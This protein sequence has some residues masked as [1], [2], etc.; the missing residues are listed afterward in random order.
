MYIPNCAYNLLR[1]NHVTHVGHGI[2]K[3]RNRYFLHTSVCQVVEEH[4]RCRRASSQTP[5]NE[6]RFFQGEVTNSQSIRSVSKIGVCDSGDFDYSALLYIIASTNQSTSITF[7]LYLSS[8]TNVLRRLPGSSST[9]KRAA[10]M[11]MVA[12]RCRNDQT[13]FSEP[14]HDN[15]YT[16]DTDNN[17]NFLK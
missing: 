15:H 9:S 13:L 10:L 1:V 12:L 8:G 7:G 11:V 4:R 14:C 6:S 3:H 5:R 17:R 16:N 2:E